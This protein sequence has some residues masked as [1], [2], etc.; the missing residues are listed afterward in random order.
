MVTFLVILGIVIYLLNAWLVDLM[1]GIAN[2]SK[3]R[4]YGFSAI[5]VIG[6]SIGIPLL[7]YFWWTMPPLVT[8]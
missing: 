8:N 5:Y 1:A 7:L 4:S 6:L 3:G 2:L